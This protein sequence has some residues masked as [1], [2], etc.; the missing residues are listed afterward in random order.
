MD[1]LTATCPKCG[2]DYGS[3]DGK[4]CPPPR[5]APRSDFR[6]DGA[7]AQPV[8]VFTSIAVA[9]IRPSPYNHRKTFTGLEELGDSIATK[10][11]AHPIVVRP[12]PPPAAGKRGPKLEPTAYELVCGERRWRAAKLK[13]IGHLPAI[14]RYLDDVEVLELQLIENVQRADVHPLEEAD[15]YHDLIERHGYTVERIVQKTGKSRSWVYGRIKLCDLVPEARE[16]FLGDKISTQVALALARMP[17]RDL[18][19]E[20]VAGVLGLAGR[21]LDEAGIDVPGLR[22]HGDYGNSKPEPLTNRQALAYLQRRYTLDLSLAKFPIDDRELLPDVGNCTN[23]VYRTGNQPDLFA[24]VTSADVCTRPPCFERKTRAWFDASAAAAKAR[25]VKVLPSADG[26]FDEYRAGDHLDNR[27]KYVDA[28]H[29]LTHADGW[30]DYSKK[31]PTL[32]KALGKDLDKVP[33]VLVQAPSGA[34]VELLDREAAVKMIK[35]AGKVELGKKASR[36]AAD[37]GEAAAKKK[38]ELRRAVCEAAVPKIASAA[39]AAFKADAMGDAVAWWRWLATAIVEQLG[40]DGTVAVAKALKIEAKRGAGGSAYDA[41]RRGILAEI[42]GPAAS[43]QA[44][45]Y[46]IAVCLIGADQAA[47]STWSPKYSDQFTAAAKRWKVD[48]DAIATDVA[49]ERKS[50]EAAKKKPAA[51]A[52]AKAGGKA[53][54]K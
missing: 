2:N 35:A 33:R 28:K 44:L 45:R 25:G 53:A 23:C 10:G 16:A 40:S 36:G 21:D 27:S 18:M 13:G 38:L 52:K 22:E 17:N 47:G 3:H 4:K 37:N 6:T 50:A 26:I 12:A 39:A 32:A 29:E 5:E 20:A 46:V 41:P 30:T 15:G 8:G 51:K 31:P 54:R 11:L 19:A 7:A 49:A 34:T 1:N 24:D 42:N 9:D 43:P 14:V 48:L